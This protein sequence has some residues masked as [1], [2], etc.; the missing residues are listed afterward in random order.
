M[1]DNLL[2][3]QLRELLLENDRQEQESLRQAL[4]KLREELHQTDPRMSELMD[5][6]INQL[7]LDFQGKHAGIILNAI[8]TKLKE[9]KDE[10][11][12]VL[13]P[14]MGKLIQKY[15][16]EEI[17]ALARQIDERLNRIFSYKTLW[18]RIRGEKISEQLIIDTMAPVV[19]EAYIV[20]KDSGLLIASFS[21]K[22]NPDQDMVA[23]M[24]TAIKQFAETAFQLNSYQ[25]LEAI[26]YDNFTIIIQNSYR[27]YTA[28]AVSGI[29]SES[30][31]KK[32][33][34]G[35]AEFSENFLSQTGRIDLRSSS[36]INQQLNS[37]F[38]EY[39]FS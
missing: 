26:E 36:F 28:L 5:E 34:T 15:I 18:R 24:F 29:V 8:D 31:E 12:E 33:R 38:N 22:Q 21:R 20:Y 30:V 35:M 23:G 4:E 37:F 7:L 9:S 11:V 17:K 25:E 16:A 27:F 14:I 39:T 1:Q 19:Q 6:K 2:L 13:Y 3:E 10:I 32:L